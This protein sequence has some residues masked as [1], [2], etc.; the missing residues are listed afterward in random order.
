M[1]CVNK[2]LIQQNKSPSPKQHCIQGLLHIPR[3]GHDPLDP[4]QY[5]VAHAHADPVLRVDFGREDAGA[6]GAEHV[7]GAEAF[8]VAL[9]R[10]ENDRVVADAV[11]GALAEGVSEEALLG[12]GHHV[13]GID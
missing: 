4:L 3:Q 5:Y 8:R 9:G 2:S 12:G 11:G 10:V 6:E 1:C 13:V 7:H